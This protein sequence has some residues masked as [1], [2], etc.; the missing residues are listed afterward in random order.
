ME[1]WLSRKKV[2]LSLYFFMPVFF[3]SFA[4]GLG[5]TIIE[6]MDR[7]L[8]AAA[9]LSSHR[10]DIEYLRWYVKAATLGGAAI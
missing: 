8:P 10:Q 4:I 9:I 5:L 1:K 3:A 7:L 6:A 2:R